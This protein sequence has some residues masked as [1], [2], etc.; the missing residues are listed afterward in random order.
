MPASA[1]KKLPSSNART[2][3]ISAHPLVSRRPTSAQLAITTSTT[4]VRIAQASSLVHTC[5]AAASPASPAEGVEDGPES[6]PAEEAEGNVLGSDAAEDEDGDDPAD[7]VGEPVSGDEV[8]DG[9]DSSPHAGPEIANNATGAS[10]A[11]TINRQCIGH[12]TSTG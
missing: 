9:V 6:A 10:S 12:H 7:E 4:P 2:A 8:A 1:S 5:T 11:A 3:D